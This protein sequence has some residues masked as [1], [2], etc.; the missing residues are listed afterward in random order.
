[1]L[2]RTGKEK[3]MI[4][5]VFKNG[6]VVKW[7]KKKYTDYRYDGRYFIVIKDKQWVGLYN[8]D[9]IATIVIK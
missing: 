4:R 5:I 1:M 7:K 2:C 9:C 6:E 3:N 8:L